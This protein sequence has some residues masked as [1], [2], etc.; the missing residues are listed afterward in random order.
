MSWPDGISELTSYLN[1]KDVQAALNA[2]A[3]QN[4]KWTEC[5]WN[6]YNSIAH[7]KSLPSIQL[8]PQLLE[9]ITISILA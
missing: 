6:V 3:F 7:D 4:P 9:T 1:R 8:L 2:D 5:N